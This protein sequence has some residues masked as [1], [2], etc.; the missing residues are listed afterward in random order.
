MVIWHALNGRRR[1]FPS[2][3]HGL[4]FFNSRS[5][6][7]VGLASGREILRSLWFQSTYWEIFSFQ[8][9]SRCESLPQNDMQEFCQPPRMIGHD[10]IRIQLQCLL[11]LP[12]IIADIGHHFFLMVMCKSRQV[13]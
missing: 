12:G 7:M 6:L 13:F 2:H 9:S 11:D 5:D 3:R 1:I 8:P 4:S 10:H